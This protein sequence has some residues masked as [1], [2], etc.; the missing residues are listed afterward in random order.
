[1]VV[2]SSSVLM[3]VFLS[4]GMAWKRPA[5]AQ[6]AQHPQ[7]R[8]LQLRLELGLDSSSIEAALLSGLA[9][10]GLGLAG[11]KV[12]NYAKLQLAAAGMI[13]GIPDGYVRY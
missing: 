13:G 1:M 10:A 12:V 7:H 6:V 9:L 5:P 11:A 3:A 8:L 2:L 4:Y